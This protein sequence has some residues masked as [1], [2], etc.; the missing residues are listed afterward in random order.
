VLL[1]GIFRLEVKEQVV[2]LESHEMGVDFSCHFR[3]WV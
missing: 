3:F 2:G 1:H